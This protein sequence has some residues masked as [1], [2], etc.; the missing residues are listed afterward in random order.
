M[1]KTQRQNGSA[2]IGLTEHFH[3]RE[4]ISLSDSFK[5]QTWSFQ[6]LLCFMGA[7]VICSHF[8]HEINGK[9]NKWRNTIS[10]TAKVC[11]NVK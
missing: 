11:N 6:E 10:F 2:L 5:D 8:M 3:Y 4:G 1:G 9:K 7:W